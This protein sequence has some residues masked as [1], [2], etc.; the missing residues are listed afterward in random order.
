[1]SIS[2]NNHNKLLSVLATLAKIRQRAT[3]DNTVFKKQFKQFKEATH[4]WRDTWIIDPLD[5][6]I[7]LVTEILNSEEKK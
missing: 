6:I 2:N 4:N 7:K 5:E 3:M 1:M